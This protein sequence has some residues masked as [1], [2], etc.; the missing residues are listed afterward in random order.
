M[1]KQA[2]VIVL[3]ALE[4]FDK[5][6]HAAIHPYLI[7]IM[8]LLGTTFGP[9]IPDENI[10]EEIKAAITEIEDGA[11]HHAHA[12]LVGLLYER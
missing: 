11:P 1:I 10:P 6:D 4:A 2:Q 3:A 7:E 8:Q 12:I 9:P 5:G